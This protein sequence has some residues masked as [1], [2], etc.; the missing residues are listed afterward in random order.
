M[1]AAVRTHDPAL[2]VLQCHHAP[3]EDGHVTH[4]Q[5]WGIGDVGAARIAAAV[6]GSGNHLGPNPYVKS[7]YLQGNGITSVGVTHIVE[8]LKDC[9]S[10]ASLNLQGNQI[11]KEGAAKIGAAVKEGVLPNVCF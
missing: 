3:R 8:G 4:D 10:V 2:T 11:G 1:L 6:A 7:L 9:P 5:R